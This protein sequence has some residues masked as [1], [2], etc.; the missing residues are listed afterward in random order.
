MNLLEMI[1]R[2][3]VLAEEFLK[4]QENQAGEIADVLLAKHGKKREEFED[5]KA[6]MQYLIREKGYKFSHINQASIENH[7]HEALFIVTDQN[8][9]EVFEARAVILKA[10]ED[11]ITV[12]GIE[13][14]EEV[15]ADLR[16]QAEQR[17]KMH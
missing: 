10:D 17:A 8:F 7:R 11:T 15:L 3:E 6:T 9:E 4:E 2:A 1:V 16:D 5:N 12:A 13:V 14:G